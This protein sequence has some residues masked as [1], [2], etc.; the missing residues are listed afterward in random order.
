MTLAAALDTDRA[1]ALRPS[2]LSL[3]TVVGINLGRLVGGAVVIETL[4]ALPGIGQMLVNAVYQHDQFVIQGVVLVIATG[5][6][7][8]N[9]LVDLM[10]AVIDPRVRISG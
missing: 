10:Y 4:F 5:F 2:S 3:V 8:I 6:V 1:L 9:L 7:L